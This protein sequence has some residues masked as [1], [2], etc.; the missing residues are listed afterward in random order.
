MQVIM[1][2]KSRSWWLRLS[3]KVV[4]MTREPLDFGGASMV[5]SGIGVHGRRVMTALDE[6]R[7]LRRA[8]A[9]WAAPDGA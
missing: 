8:G 4:E 1:V 3:Y 6:G 7:A 2:R 9:G 5:T